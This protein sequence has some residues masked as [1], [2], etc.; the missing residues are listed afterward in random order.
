MGTSEPRVIST[1][2]M[3][4]RRAPRQPQATTLYRLVNKHLDAFLDDT[5]QRQ[6]LP[7]FIERTFRALLDCGLPEKGCLHL[8]CGHCGHQELV[9]FSCK[10][11]GVC[12]SCTTRAANDGSARLTK[13]VLP[14]VGHRH[15]VVSYPFEVSQNLAFQPKLISKIERIVLTV[16][17][18]WEETRG[19]ACKTG[20][21][22]FRHRFG[23]N[24]S[25]HIH[26]HIVMIDGGF[27]ENDEGKLVFV[28]A[29][30]IGMEELNELAARLHRR[31]G[32]CL[33]RNGVSKEA[34]V[35]RTISDDTENPCSGLATRIRGLHVFVSKPVCDRKELER[36]CRYLLRSGV[37]V[38]RLREL[39]DGRY[40]YRL[41]RKDRKGNRDLVLTGPEMLGRLGSLIPASRFPARRYFG[42][43]GGGAKWRRRVIP[44]LATLKELH[45]AGKPVTHSRT[46][47]AALLKRVYG[48]DALMCPMCKTL[49]ELVRINVQ[50]DSPGI[51]RTRI[52]GGQLL[53]YG[54]TA[55]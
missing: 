23:E 35:P 54:P 15:W 7:G 22:L 21:V 41:N 34:A 36:L 12:P 39:P 4:P 16:L 3:E 43:L 49:M 37:D 2:K 55:A 19:I 44:L 47:W 20:G 31:I 33:K 9:A 40:A 42:V 29:A 5:G 32:K 8:K 48:I 10:L 30:D 1:R 50:G 11:R 14:E 53:L 24:L 18:H 17:R 46:D 27:R 38:S 52:E 26:S 25:L 6:V 45:S 28:Q 51:V 13:L